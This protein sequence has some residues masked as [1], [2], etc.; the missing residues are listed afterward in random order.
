MNQPRRSPLL[1]QIATGDPRPI[2]RQIVDGVKR[3]IASGDLAVGAGLPSVR[4][5][6]A[7]LAVNPNTVAKAYTELTTEGWLDARVGLGLFVATPRQRL[8]DAERERRLN[9][10]LVRFVG[11]H[12]ARLP[13]RRPAGPGGRRTGAV[14][15]ETAR[16]TTLV[17][18]HNNDRDPQMNLPLPVAIGDFVIETDALTLRFRNKLALD[19]RP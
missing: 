5:L 17:P 1:L 11:H 4:G 2:N 7:Q 13:G 6:A 16:L 9:D 10:A 12:R 8:S 19:R 3:L 18:P 15:A 14:R